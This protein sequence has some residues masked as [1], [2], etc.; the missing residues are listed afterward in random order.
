MIRNKVGQFIKE[1]GMSSMELHRQTKIARTTISR[2]IN[3]EIVNI[4][5]DTVD[6]LC[7]TMGCTLADLFEYVPDEEMTKAD[8]IAVAERKASVTHYSSMRKKKT[9]GE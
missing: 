4:N 5:M 1:S 3:N 8:K 6:T 2:M 9:E 7:R